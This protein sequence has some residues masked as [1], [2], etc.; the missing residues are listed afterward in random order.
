MAINF[1]KSFCLRIGPRCDAVCANITSSEGFVIV[2]ASEMRYLCVYFTK[3]RSFRCSLDYAK[4]SFYRAANSIFGKIGRVASGEVVL[5]LIK[6]K[7]VPVLVI[8]R[9]FMK[10]FN[11]N[12]IEIVKACQECLSFEL[13]SEQLTKRVVKFESKEKSVTV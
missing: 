10:L 7:C 6:S 1:K 8:N 4:R 9:F 3:S 12:N 2:W 11:T 13:P 5:Q